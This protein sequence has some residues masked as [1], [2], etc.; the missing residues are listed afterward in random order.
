MIL[1]AIVAIVL[2]VYGVINLLSGRIAWALILFIA[3]C[4]IGPG[5]WAIYK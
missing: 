2:A 1:L 3:A 5:G 4:A